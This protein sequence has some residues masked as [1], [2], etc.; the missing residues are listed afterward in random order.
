LIWS[1]QY[2]PE[3][4]KFEIKYGCEGFDVSNNFPY[5]IFSRFRM[6]FELKFEQGS[7]IQVQMDFDWI[8]FWSLIFDEIWT[9]GLLFHLDDNSTHENEFDIS[10]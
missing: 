6:E 9:I 5:W 1:K 10:N 2:I 7:K 3:L 8:F 4:E